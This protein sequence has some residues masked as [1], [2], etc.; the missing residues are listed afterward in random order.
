MTGL[1]AEAI[2][3]TPFDGSLGTKP[4]FVVNPSLSILA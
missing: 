1:G 3:A 4:T 2:S